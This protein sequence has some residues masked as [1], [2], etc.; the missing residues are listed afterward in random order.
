MH[1]LHLAC[2]EL[3]VSV[4][5]LNAASERRPYNIVRFHRSFRVAVASAV[6]FNS[7]YKR[8]AADF[9]CVNVG[10]S[11]TTPL[12]RVF[13]LYT[14][15][16]PSRSKTSS[17]TLSVLYTRVTKPLFISAQPPCGSRTCA[18]CDFYAWLR[19]LHLCMIS[20]KSLH[21][22]STALHRSVVETHKRNCTMAV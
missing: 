18:M 12:S 11:F 13:L 6:L 9:R 14:I 5:C 8:S 7:E 3:T 22:R 4:Q 20:T 2:V 15:E 10:V 19:R 21:G 16:V 1:N 17:C